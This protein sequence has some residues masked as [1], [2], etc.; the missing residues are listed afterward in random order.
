MEINEQ[1][2]SSFLYI[3]MILESLCLYD[4][5]LVLQLFIYPR[6]VKR[7]GYRRSVML[8]LFL[9]SI[10]TVL[11]PLSNVITGPIK[12]DDEG[13][14]D[15]NSSTSIVNASSELDFCGH[16]LSADGSE[17]LVNENSVVR[18]P[19][20]VWI[21]LTF[22]MAVWVIS[23][24]VEFLFGHSLIKIC[25]SFDQLHLFFQSL[26][27]IYFAEVHCLHYQLPCSIQQQILILDSTLQKQKKKKIS[28]SHHTEILYNKSCVLYSKCAG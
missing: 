8:G 15:F 25:G 10:M 14:G 19:A 2:P 1:N 20:R 22:H 5:A 24:L 6:I 7:I 11:F 28:I 13:S 16:N 18:V 23:R 27:R 21:W 3:H 17:N 4:Y 9:F 26:L 12:Q